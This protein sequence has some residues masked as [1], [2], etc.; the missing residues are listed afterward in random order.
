MAHRNSYNSHSETLRTPSLSSPSSETPS[1]FSNSWYSFPESQLLPDN[2]TLEGTTNIFDPFTGIHPPQMSLL[3]TQINIESFYDQKPIIQ[4][5]H[6][7]SSAPASSF[8]SDHLAD[9]NLTHLPDRMEAPSY[10]FYHSGA[11][12]TSS[13]NLPSRSLYPTTYSHTYVDNTRPPNEDIQ[14]ALEWPTPPGQM[15]QPS[16]FKHHYD[17]S[18]GPNQI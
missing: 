1:V 8:D 12:Y 11:P 7:V 5:M 14:S 9:G 13:H 16:D 17:T 10:N 18:K 3:E 6:S 2:C 4:S 15:I